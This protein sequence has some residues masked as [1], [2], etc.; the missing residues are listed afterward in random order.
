MTKEAQARRAR[1]VPFW[2]FWLVGI[3]GLTLIALIAV[4]SFWTVKTNAVAN[5]V[6]APEWGQKASPASTTLISTKSGEDDLPVVDWDY[7]RSVNPDVVAWLTVPNT[8]I[9]LPVVQAQ[10]GAPQ[11]YL[12]HDVYKK[13]NPMG[14]VYVDAAC[15]PY[16]GIDSYCPL[17]FGH[18][19]RGNGQMFSE[20]AP[21][22][23]PEYI[24]GR[25]EIILQT[26]AGVRRY[27][28]SCVNTVSAY[29]GADTTMCM[30]MEDY[31][32]GISG[33]YRQADIQLS[34]PA[35]AER[36][37]ELVTCTYTGRYKD[38]RTCVYGNID[39]P[40]D[41]TTATL[42]GGE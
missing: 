34:S 21:A 4:L 14:A 3:I 41:E 2:V 27:K 33:I 1:R 7:W 6:P 17:L 36:G 25:Q 11:Y 26:P 40:K 10:A 20:L 23:D 35:D 22:T 15:A 13:F 32:Y 42:G 19:V 24:N 37:I 30:S 38:E 5:M 16:G 39:L 29:A 12:W 9:S 8:N 31:R 28:V 18:D